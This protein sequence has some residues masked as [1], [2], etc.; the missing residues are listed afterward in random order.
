MADEENRPAK[1]VVRKTAASAG[2]P[3][4][5]TKTPVK[6]TPTARKGPPA[7]PTAAATPAAP[8]AE[9]APAPVVPTAAEP[10]PAPAPA[11][12]KRVAK[13]PSAKASVSPEERQ[14]MI[15]EA[16]YYRAE[17]RGFA[18]G[19]EAEDWAAAEQE[20]DAQLAGRQS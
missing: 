12:A 19:Y 16:A 15:E 2:A 20:I 13:H 9:P 8:V 6:K 17:K 18:P 11:A 1:R 14:R 10:E 3:A 4:T 7:T 5:P